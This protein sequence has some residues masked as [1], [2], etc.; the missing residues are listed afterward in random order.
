MPWLGFAPAAVRLDER[1][2][3]VAD[4]DLRQPTGGTALDRWQVGGGRDEDVAHRALHRMPHCRPP[5]E[6][7]REPES[8]HPGREAFGFVRVE[9]GVGSVPVGD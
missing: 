6:L 1:A 9:E 2:P 5:E 3:G 7:V 4:R 8:V